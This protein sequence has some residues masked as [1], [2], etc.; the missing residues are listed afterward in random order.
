[1][2][3]GGGSVAGSRRPSSLDLTKAETPSCNPSANTTPTGGS[4]LMNVSS[5]RIQQEDG[6]VVEEGPTMI[7]DPGS[8][9]V[10]RQC[11]A[12]KGPLGDAQRV[13][14]DASYIEASS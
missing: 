2:S 7:P 5:R 1:M 6:A 4:P 3:D 13:E 14:F 11:Y 10:Q 8:Q 12:S 9:Q